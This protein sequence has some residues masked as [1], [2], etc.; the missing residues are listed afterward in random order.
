MN[1][2]CPSVT[3]APSVPE[4]QKPLAMSLAFPPETPSAIGRACRAV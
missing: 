3:S 2:R 4:Q 1:C